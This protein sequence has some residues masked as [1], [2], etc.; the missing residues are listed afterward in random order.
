MGDDIPPFCAPEGVSTNNHLSHAVRLLWH[1]CRAWACL[2][3]C[4]CTVVTD[5][6]SLK[7][8]QRQQ[9][10]S[11]AGDRQCIYPVIR[12]TQEE[13]KGKERKKEKGKKRQTYI[14]RGDLQSTVR[15][16]R[17]LP[18]AKTSVCHWLS[19]SRVPRNP[20]FSMTP[21]CPLKRKC[22]RFLESLSPRMRR[23]RSSLLLT[24]LTSVSPCCSLSVFL[25]SS[26]SPNSLF[27]TLFG[28]IK[29]KMYSFLWKANRKNTQTYC[30][31]YRG[32][33]YK[34]STSW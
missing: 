8:I 6:L 32:G 26:F 3:Q 25:S 16:T 14:S 31:W 12:S 7:G 29:V 28:S 34:Q 23:P 27:S 17:W 1:G 10:E 11:M 15:L 19:A 22:R 4:H 30:V 33:K 2:E 20:Q 5:L 24:R 18:M 21:L 13:Q 9:E